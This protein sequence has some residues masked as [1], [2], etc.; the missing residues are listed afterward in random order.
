MHLFSVDTGTGGRTSTNTA[1]ALIRL[2]TEVF[3][4]EGGAR[5]TDIAIPR[6]AV[7]ITDGRSN[8][9]ASLTIPSALA[10]REG[11]TTVYSVGV[12][13]NIVMEELLAIASSPKNV[14]LLEGFDVTEFDGLRSRI[15]NDACLGKSLQRSHGRNYSCAKQIVDA[16]V[17][18][19]FPPMQM[20]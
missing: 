13:D 2:R 4:L 10:L 15:T 11:G 6:V 3:T 20:M 8:V 1:D 9:N 18:R 12:G 5:A 19:S 16:R 17:T 14:Q 7:V